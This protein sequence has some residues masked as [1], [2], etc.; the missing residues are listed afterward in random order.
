MERPCRWA[1]QCSPLGLLPQ[2]AGYKS[3][4]MESNVAASL[5]G[6]VPQV[7]VQTGMARLGSPVFNARGQAIGL[8]SYGPG[9]S[10]LLNNSAEALAA[11]QSPAKFYVP[12][13]DFLLSFQDLPTPQKPVA[14][15][16]I[17][18]PQLTGLNKDVA[19][20][21]DLKNQPAIQVGE[22]IHDTPA[23]QS[24][25]KQGDIIVKLN[26]QPLERGDEAAELPS[27]FRRQ[28]LRMKPGQ[29]VTLSVLRQRTSR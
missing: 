13:R 28:L 12:A 14:L 5:R 17:G 22:V 21:Y 11:I 7:L 18:V 2:A 9:Q 26:G 4:F 25:L 1:T 24:G 19:E 3:Y 8:V 15:P 23:E 16:W 27:I 29:E 20:A 10:F 6:E